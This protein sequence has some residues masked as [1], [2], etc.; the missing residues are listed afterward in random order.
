MK[1]FE[2]GYGFDIVCS[3]CNIYFK[4]LTPICLFTLQLVWF[5]D[6]DKL[7]YPKVVCSLVL[8]A[9]CLRMYQIT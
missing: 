8:K 9:T 6:Q 2:Y 5:Y 3:H 4:F 7:S 1:L